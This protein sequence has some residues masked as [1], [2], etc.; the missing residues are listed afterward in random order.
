[1][2]PLTGER[3]ARSRCTPAVWCVGEPDVCWG[4]KMSPPTERPTRQVLPRNRPP[5]RRPDDRKLGTCKLNDVDPQAWLADVLARLRDHPASR[6]FEMLPRNW[7]A[8][9][10]AIAT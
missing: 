1:M 10:L 4:S 6:I 2:E 3:L 8:A 7:K 9:R 5:W